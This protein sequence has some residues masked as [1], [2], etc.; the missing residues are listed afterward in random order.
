MANPDFLIRVA[1]L[2][3][4]VYFVLLVG[5]SLWAFQGR[6]PSVIK[7][8]YA[9]GIMYKSQMPFAYCWRQAV[10]KEDLH[11]FEQARVRH[12]VF[13]ISIVVGALV[14][15]IYG[16]VHVVVSLWKCNMQ[17]AGLL[18]GQ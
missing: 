14:I 15:A 13:L 2:L 8:K 7:S 9:S 3:L 17:G 18:H 6:V 11:V 5:I 10:N 12:H 16:Y 1:D 4:L